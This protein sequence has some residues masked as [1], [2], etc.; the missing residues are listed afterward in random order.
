MMAAGREGEECGAVVGIRHR[1]VLD[2]DF[3]PAVAWC[4]AYKAHTESEPRSAP[5]AIAVGRPDG[6]ASCWEG[7]ILPHDGAFVERN[8]RHVERIV[9]LLLWSRGGSRVLIAG[10]QALVREIALIYG[11]DGRRAFDHDMF[12]RIF[13]E[14]LTVTAR[15]LDEMPANATSVMPLGRH[16]EGCRVG[17]DLGGSDRKS[18]AVIDGRVVHSEEVEWSP[19]FASDPQYH[20]DG[21]MDSIRRAAAYLPRV[22]AIGG[23]AAGVYVDN[24]PRV[25]SLFRGVSDADFTSEIRPIF[26]RLRTAWGD[27]P[28]EVAND[29]EVTALAASMSSGEGSVLG[30]AMGTSQA[31]GYC[32][33][34]GR[35]AGWLNELAFVPVDYRDDAP[36]DEWSGDRGCGVQYFSQQA[37][38]RLAPRAGIELAAD[39]PHAE[40][41]ASV[42]R[43]IE[44]GDPRSRKIFET[45]GVYLGYSI[46][47]YA[48]WYEIRDLLLLGRV[49]S[50]EGGSVMIAKAEEVLRD[51]FPAL[52]E[53]I[54]ITTPDEHLRRH[55]QA[56]A[57]ASLPV[58]EPQGGTR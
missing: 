13:L 46:A 49:T 29:G 9:K 37:V 57:A 50:G 16:L 1:P 35:V 38:A 21:I 23:S 42:Q 24:E 11:P 39:M 14:P 56:I 45:I 36:I 12:G 30:I 34:S 25:A 44:Q 31:A 43:L 2:R 3:V 41:L 15:E 55:G 22:D 4:A 53:R 5:I 54:R 40:Q 6:R 33:A 48:E 52:A 20:F 18:A 51:E 10:P 26:H 27:V 47:W 28:F 19:Y 58:I 32:D 7:M 17:F 8:L